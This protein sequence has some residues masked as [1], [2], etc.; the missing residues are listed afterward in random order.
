MAG[1][2][3]GPPRTFPPRADG[4]PRIAGAG[5]VE[6]NQLRAA[7]PVRR[8]SDPITHVQR[9]VPGHEEAREPAAIAAGRIRDVEISGARVGKARVGRDAVA[10]GIDAVLPGVQRARFEVFG[11][12]W[13]DGR[14]RYVSEGMIRSQCEILRRAAE[15]E[16]G[17]RGKN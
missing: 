6:R 2:E 8:K 4:G 11:E 9:V 5:A 15:E 3:A 17:E 10:R 14:L 1:K 13:V 7:E 16:G 12:D